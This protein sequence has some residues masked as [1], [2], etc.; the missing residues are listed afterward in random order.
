MLSKQALLVKT[1]QKFTST[2]CESLCIACSS[3]IPM[4]YTY[5]ATGPVFITCMCPHSIGRP[6]HARVMTGG[7]E[8]DVFMGPKAEVSV[9]W[10]ALK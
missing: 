6:K 2:V 3:P 1:I 7:L 4:S 5:M 9:N 8:G 10:N